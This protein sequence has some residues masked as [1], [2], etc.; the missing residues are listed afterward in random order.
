VPCFVRWPGQFKAGTVRNGI[1]THQDWLATRN[2][3]DMQGLG[4]QVV[5]PWVG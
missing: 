2:L 5:D 4:V 1:V 3:R